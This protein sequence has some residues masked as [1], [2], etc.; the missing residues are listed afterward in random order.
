MKS[1]HLTTG[2]GENYLKYILIQFPMTECKLNSGYKAEK[3]H[4][5]EKKKLLHIYFL[6]FDNGL[7]KVKQIILGWFNL[8][9]SIHHFSVFLND[10]SSVLKIKFINIFHL[11]LS[12]ASDNFS[13]NYSCWQKGLI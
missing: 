2:S 7:Y 4:I 8:Y 6:G 9:L 13:L 5:A 11:S 10:P 1:H 12:P 3:N